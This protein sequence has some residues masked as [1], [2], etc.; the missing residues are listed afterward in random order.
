MPV[1]VL[2]KIDAISIEELDLIYKILHSVP[3][4][5]SNEWLNVD[6]LIEKL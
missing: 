5:S 1:K 2:N 4:I 6:E 3:T